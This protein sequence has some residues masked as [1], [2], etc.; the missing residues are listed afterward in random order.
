MSKCLWGAYANVDRQTLLA[1][2]TAAA[3]GIATGTFFS[4]L[5]FQ[6]GGVRR[7]TKGQISNEIWSSVQELVVEL[8]TG[9]GGIKS[10]CEWQ[11]LRQTR[12]NGMERHHGIVAKS[13]PILHSH[14][15]S[16]HANVY[17]LNGT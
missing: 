5:L 14:N 16:C 10:S 17:L 9:K 4:L 1:P 11:W 13:E 2:F 7:V 8:E 15:T 6:N 3:D 12:P